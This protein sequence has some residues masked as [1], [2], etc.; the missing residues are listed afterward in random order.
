MLV[1]NCR[2]HHGDG[3]RALCQLADHNP[4]PTVVN[5]VDQPADNN[6]GHSA[7]DIE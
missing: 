5:D 7:A 6:D 3:S 2:V 4:T 1:R